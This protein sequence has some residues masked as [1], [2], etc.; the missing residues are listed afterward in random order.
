M[1]IEKKTCEDGIGAQED[2]DKLDKGP[3]QARGESNRDKG[4]VLHLGGNQPE[5]R[6][7][8]VVQPGAPSVCQQPE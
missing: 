7:E 4:S 1:E 5:Q 2:L 3:K 8:K 6:E